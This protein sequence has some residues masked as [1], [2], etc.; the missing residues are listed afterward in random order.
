MDRLFDSEFVILDGGMGTMLQRAGLPAGCIPEVFTLEHPEILENIHRS[1]YDAG[2]RIAFAN[3]FSCNSRKLSASGYTVQELVSASVAAARRGTGGRAKIALDVGPIGELM[4]PTGTLSFDEAYELFR[5]VV[6]AGERAGV[7]IISFETFTDLAELRVGV[8]AAKENTSLPIFTTMSCEQSGRSFTGCLAESFAVVMTGLGVDALGVNCS[9][10]PKE[11]MAT[12]RRIAAVTPLSLIVKPNAGLPDARDGHYSIDAREFAEEMAECAQIGVR[13]VGGCCGTTPE[14]I[15]ALCEVLA[16]KK[17]AKRKYEPRTRVC[18][19]LRMVEVNEVRVIGERINPTGKKRFAQALREG[20]MDYVLSQGVAQM[21]AGAD[22]LDVNVGA[23][24]LNEPELMSNC[25]MGL[26]AVCDLPLQIDSND[27][28]ALEA[29]LRRFCGKAIV[30]SV[31]GERARLDAVLPIAQ[32]YGAAV[33]A[34]TMDERG[35]P[36]TAQERFEI[37]RGIMD[38]CVAR[39]IPKEDIFIDCLCLTVSAN[40]SSAAQTL[41]ALRMV[42][43]RLELHTVLGVSNISFGLPNRELIN[44]SFLML[45]MENGLD[46]PIINPNIPSMMSAVAAFKLL[47]GFDADC[48]GFVERFAEATPMSAAPARTSELSITEAVCKGMRAE[49]AEITRGLLE[50]MSELDIINELLIPA[51]DIV[52]ERYERGEL[53]LPQLIRAAEA[54]CEAFEV[55]KQSIAKKGDGSVS[56]GKILVATVKGDIH[57]IGK[58]IVKTILSNY[59]YQV[60]DLG[61]DVAPERVV[62]AA[63]REKVRLVGLSALMTTTLPAMAETIK[64]LRRSGHDCKIFVGG[65][66]LTP[67]YAAEIG[68]DYYAKDAKRSVDIAKEVLG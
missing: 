26:Q 25:V 55:L 54:S 29:G 43:E 34:L 15:A 5:E 67:E 27:P 28:A 44:S 14:Y 16:D 57:D 62:E 7:D 45:A 66:V 42:K 61:R 24:G 48:K 52:G 58:N 36:E 51:L 12:V 35:I 50:N 53:F 19:A 20:D 64:Q 49:A 63:I 33:V 18:S 3:T 8:L 23:P 68:A 6:V 46:L 22:I 21:D 56:K 4:E 10:G 41:D 17:C 38:E 1:Y 60:L 59:G 65:A 11:L 31:N 2:S 47:R 39:G 13:Y 30:N 32:K 9:L 37:A 40:Q